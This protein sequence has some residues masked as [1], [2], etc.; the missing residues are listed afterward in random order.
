MD[1]ATRRS[2]KAHKRRGRAPGPSLDS[3]ECYSRD[4]LSEL[5]SGILEALAESPDGSRMVRQGEA[6]E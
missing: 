1:L 6:S 3:T 2:A 4:E 5:I